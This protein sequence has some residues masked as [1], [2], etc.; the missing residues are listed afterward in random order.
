MARLAQA[1]V[2]AYRQREARL[3]AIEATNRALAEYARYRQAFD[4]QAHDSNRK[5]RAGKARGR[6]RDND[7]KQPSQGG[8]VFR[9]GTGWEPSKELARPR[10]PK[11]AERGTATK[12]PSP[13]QDA[14]EDLHLRVIETALARWQ[15]M[16]AGA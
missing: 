7:H 8:L 2:Q 10:S 3:R 9:P 15:K 1:K 6:E 14:I 5:A 11:A 4:R 16:L 12:P 13:M